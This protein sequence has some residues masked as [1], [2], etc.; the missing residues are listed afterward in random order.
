MILSATAF[1]FELFK[2]GMKKKAALEG[3]EGLNV[4]SEG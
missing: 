4:V 2:T 1:W 3:G